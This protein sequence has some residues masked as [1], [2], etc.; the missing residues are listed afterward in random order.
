M[1]SEVVCI[2]PATF[3]DSYLPLVIFITLYFNDKSF[4]HNFQFSILNFQF[5][6]RGLYI[7]DL[8]AAV[9]EGVVGG[10][11]ALDI[12]VVYI[13]PFEDGAHIALVPVLVGHL[14]GLDVLLD[15]VLQDGEVEVDALRPYH[16]LVLLG[17]VGEVDV[18]IVDDHADVASLS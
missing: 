3:L 17:K 5:T 18:R 16:E 9:V 8:C 10:A 2:A 12:A 15:G 14:L 1:V 7:L 13:A 11:G 6:K 4:L